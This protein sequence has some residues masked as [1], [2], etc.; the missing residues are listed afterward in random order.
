MAA[1]SPGRPSGP[2]R[3]PK[4]QSATTNTHRFEPF[5]ERIAKLRVDPVHRVQQNQFTPEDTGL[6]TTHFGQSLNHWAELNL[7]EN[8]IHFVQKAKPLCESLPQII[9]HAD[10]IFA[11]LLHHIAER[12]V[13]SSEP[14]LSLLA[15]FAHDLGARFEKYFAEAVN[16]VLSVAATHDAS[17][18]IEWSFSC[19]AWMFKF[20]SRLL[21]P[22]L[23]PL[24]T[25]I[26][27]YLGRSRQKPYVI[28][29]AAESMA[30][31]IRKAGNMYH[32][33][34]FPLEN[35]MSCLFEDL[36]S[37][38][39]Q[40]EKSSYQLGLM[41]LFSEAV[42][43]IDGELH[44]S[45][46]EIVGC[47]IDHAK[48]SN[49]I[50]NPHLETLEGVVI[51]II[52][53][54][55][56]DG[57]FPLAKLMRD[58]SRTLGKRSQPGDVAV[59]ARLL[60]VII[61]TRKGSRISDWITTMEGLV[62]VAN[63]ASEPA[64]S[65]SVILQDILTTV[66]MTFQF[67][68]L[69]A[70]LPFSTRLMDHLSSGPLSRYFLPFCLLT[71]QLGRDRFQ[72]LV[73]PQ[74]QKYIVR[75]WQQDQLDCCLAVRQLT[76]TG[77]HVSVPSQPGCPS[78]QYSID[79]E[80]LRILCADETVPE[81]PQFVKDA[82][83]QFA[84]DVS[85]P[86]DKSVA[87]KF[88][89]PLRLQSLKMLRK[90]ESLNV[91]S[92]AFSAG[93]GLKTYVRLAKFT[94]KLDKSLWME[95]CDSAVLPAHN[96]IFLT[97][98]S[99]YLE[100]LDMNDA[101]LARA[102]KLMKRLT[103][104]LLN[105]VVEIKIISVRLMHRIMSQIEIQDLLSTILQI[106]ETPYDLR[107]VR[108]ITMLIRRLV[109]LHKNVKSDTLLR[110][111]ASYFLLGLLTSESGPI[112]QEVHSAIYTMCE[113][114]ADEE[115][116]SDLVMRSLQSSDHSS[117]SQESMGDKQTPTAKP[118]RYQ[119]T[120]IQKV[121]EIAEKAFTLFDE[122]KKN[123]DKMLNGQWASTD[124]EPILLSRLQALQVLKIIPQ[125]AERRSRFVVPVFLSMQPA[126][127]YVSLCPGSGA[128][129]SS[130]TLS[131][132]L[133]SCAW[134]FPE[135]KAFLELFGKFKNPK[136]LYKS[137]Q[138]FD[139]L[140]ECL[141]AGQSEIQ[142]LALQALF[143]WK[144]PGVRRY[145]ESLLKLTD[146]K[147]YRDE[148]TTLF[149]SD[150]ES[151][152]IRNEDRS[153]LLP[154]LLRLL[155]G[156]MINRSGSKANHG[157]QESKRKTT[158]RMLF[159]MQH[160]E[161]AD[162]LDIAFGKTSI[163]IGDDGSIQHGTLSVDVMSIEKQNGLV[164]A[165]ESMLETLQGQMAPFG[166]RIL[167]PVLYCLYRA[168]QRL[169][170]MRRTDDASKHGSK[171]SITRNIRRTALHCL[172]MMSASCHGINWPIY[173]PSIFKYAIEPKLD[174]FAVENAQGISGL[175][176]LFA[177]WSDDASKVP[178]L[179]IYNESL[180]DRVADCLVT[181][182]TK[183][184]VKIYILDQIFLRLPQLAAEN[185]NLRQQILSVLRARM[186]H[187]LRVLGLL[188]E[189]KE[190]RKVLDSAIA[191]VASLTPLVD[192][193]VEIA[194]LLSACT[195][196][197]E[198]SSDRVGPRVKGDLLQ[199]VLHLLRLTSSNAES[200]VHG[201][202]RKTVSS[203]FN[204]F[205]DSPSRSALAEILEAQYLGDPQA[206]ITVSLC[207][208][209]NAISGDKLDSIDYDSRL[210]AF[211]AINAM[212]V[213][214]L[215]P[216]LWE[217]ILQNL[218]YFARTA[219]DFAIRSNA[220]SSLRRFISAACELQQPGVHTLLQTTIFEAVRKAA[221][222]D[223][224]AVRADHLALFGLIVQKCRSW[225]EISD[226]QG[227]LVSNDEDAS[228]FNNILHIQHHR[229]TRAMRRLA[230]EAE[231]GVL[232]STNICHFFLPLLEKFIFDPKDDEG[233]R[234]LRGQAIVT[235]GSLLQWVEWGQ[236]RAILRRYKSYINNKM[237]AEKDV[238]KLL[239]V[240][241]DALISSLSLETE[242]QDTEMQGLPGVK[243]QT[244][245][246]K[247]LPSM[248]RLSHE[249]GTHFIPDLAA[250]IHQKDESQVTSRIPVAITTVKLLQILPQ[251]QIAQFLP[252]L[253][254][255]IAYILRS[256]SQDSRDIARRTLAEATS[257]LGPSCL[258]WTLKELR[259]ALGRGY[260]L[261]VLSY[262]VH[263]IL[264]SNTDHLKP[265]DLDHCLDG[266]VAVITDDIFGVV[267]QEKDAEDYI[268]KMREVKSRKSFDS[269]E[270][271]A[272]STTVQHLMRLIRPLQTLLTGNIS[273]KHSR[274]VDE[275]L[276]RIGIGLS[277][278][279][280]AG[281]R[282]VLIFSYEV[283]QELYHSMQPAKEYTMTNDELNRQ[284]FLVQASGPNKT[285]A[286][287]DSPSVYKLAKFAL[288]LVRSTLQK[289]DNLLKPESVHGFLPVIGD[290][291]VQ[292]QE[293]VKSSAMRLLS[294]IIKLPMPELQE[295]ASMYVVEAV[296]VVKDSIST[297]GEAPQAALKLVAAILR[298]RRSVHI[299]D[300]DLSFLLHRIMPDLEQPDRQGVTFNLIKAV[301]ARKIMLPEVYD[302]SK[303]IGMMMIT[304][305]GQ[306]ARDA[307]RGVF[308]HFVLE[309][310]QSKER[311][312]KQIK[313]LVK[314]LSYQYPEGRQSTMEAI[315]ML[316]NKVGE[317]VAQELIAKIFIPLILIMA[318]D[319]NA[320]CR[321]MA[322]A[323]LSRCFEKADAEQLKSLLG[324]L[325][326]WVQ[327][328]GNLALRKTGMQ[329]FKILFE[330]LG[331]KAEKEVPALLSEICQI[332]KKLGHSDEG[333][334]W[335]TIYHALQLVL[336]ITA[337]FPALAMAH[338]QSLLW[339]R[340][341]ALLTYPHPWVQSSSAALMGACFHDFAIANGR[342]S[343]ASLPLIGGHGLQLTGEAQL[344]VLRS[345]LRVLKRN[346]SSPDLSAQLVRNLVFLGRCFIA[347]SLSIDTTASSTTREVEN[348]DLDDDEEHESDD[349]N[350]VQPQGTRLP[351][352][353]HL[354]T[355]LSLILRHEPRKLTS[356]TLLP[357][358]SSLTL[359]AALIHHT[360]TT[361]LDSLLPT[362]I[363]PL[364]HLTDPHLP[365]PNSSSSSSTD[366]NFGSTFRDLIASASEVLDLLQKKVGATEYVKAMTEA[367]RLRR[368]KREG[369]RIKRRLEVVRD[370]EA[371]AR[372][373]RRRGEK[374][375]RRKVARGEGFRAAR[376]GL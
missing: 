119:C 69:D 328:S 319:D 369:R 285:P 191:V 140:L 238:I 376:R 38:K 355:Q 315:S 251:A 188:L 277:R 97:A 181:P 12:D 67:S 110:Q 91:T 310:P 41:S 163:Q 272:K 317:S 100:A 185:P 240:S 314:N 207:S 190:T 293:D 57:F 211:S 232:R 210:E 27:P 5:S 125:A 244:A 353:A 218:I 85:L 39:N 40:K 254:L 275:L 124:N 361:T 155:Y 2:P 206:I 73:L 175:L 252:P 300:S 356:A 134:T 250:F 265:G 222:A 204:Y 342:S 335:E 102:P 164:R 139:A 339:S 338:Q 268:S 8:F 170:E 366:P 295:N 286:S 299:R 24:L 82:F 114:S 169:D 259:T 321:E 31:L 364:A 305:H 120:N 3:K 370:P 256:R 266:L 99:E 201:Q 162:F 301:M 106:L 375:K 29:F 249:L 198:E 374:E 149:H 142:K 302:A 141:T 137:Q 233:V 337:M 246:G 172:C 344:D 363:L 216:E 189:S 287:R 61:G 274:Q 220:V 308:V 278:N 264:V 158:L 292:A 202:L 48:Q 217:P 112:V 132:E 358:K 309:Y 128:S 260:Q 177:T 288:D 160:S 330:V 138:V 360:P 81:S 187:L 200:L 322:G 243:R 94:D 168:C 354:L 68:P 228:F 171:N 184:A 298:E 153:E 144:L 77:M 79:E 25:I 368:E 74:L 235:V 273:S 136:V 45:S 50:D 143:T 121:K 9:H 267:G 304:N 224:E 21:V 104:N 311:W 16:L 126:Q 42:R 225:T 129:T 89:E 180:L 282:D 151:S 145:E 307:A 83:A 80:I 178:Y 101:E 90:E 66:A 329:A 46:V 276:R 122:P 116:V 223:S 257:I 213:A 209:L 33:N 4:K 326:G 261:H 14:L 279:P 22:D 174:N 11:L 349:L 212:D 284:R 283:I 192:S 179:S 359:L 154:I 348:S 65:S 345:S 320:G 159:K 234:N 312:N 258:N 262:T 118:N 63:I 255:D 130:H 10:S 281:S 365:T 221:K 156:Q 313:F 86:H 113:D 227:L 226:M 165:A 147:T 269:M 127:D 87:I 331:I 71:D 108:Q 60:R 336:K 133:I 362:T 350:E 36:Q 333:E 186:Q 117:P 334:T 19:L 230:A 182:S 194:G 290:A 357:K 351:A 219:D 17:E 146:E 98:L 341:R 26:A 131:P 107:T 343:L 88:V 72:S 325:Q 109:V 70:L 78:S 28:R 346:W 62:H 245:L 263:S 231:Q 306:S 51:S 7:S 242:N 53:E 76:A 152:S 324:S 47:L 6:S 105:R 176:Q 270:L 327:Q 49:D 167:A 316:L 37:V 239:G 96:P 253:L 197:L 297:N 367:Q 352:I 84:E 123:L 303:K 43:G 248:E 193:T 20:L 199:A 215:I 32:K 30:F 111:V 214:D 236:F 318:N 340:I 271:L 56:A 294:A 103:Q 323:L 58:F 332:V 347:N 44:S 296:K 195:T 18:V 371:A 64:Y 55:T 1:I 247:S 93:R 237:E 280:I 59:S 203:L 54:T 35:V 13:V 92:M 95:V 291:L 148:L 75:E 196:L 23:R 150:V 173:L 373:K 205:R 115:V 15:H 208:R 372:S 161:I 52:H 34:K 229:R 183:D 289:H 135:R 157:G 166:E 241:A